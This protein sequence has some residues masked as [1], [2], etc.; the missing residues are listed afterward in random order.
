MTLD[1]VQ[2]IEQFFKDHK[3]YVSRMKF[4]R[5]HYPEIVNNLPNERIIEQLYRLLYGIVDIP[6]CLTCSKP[7]EF[8]TFQKGYKTFC[9]HKCAVSNKQTTLKRKKTNLEKYGSE[10]L[11]DCLEIREKRK[12]TMLLKY[13]SEH[14][15]QNLELR[16]V[17][18][19]K[20]R[21]RKQEDWD[22]ISKKRKETN[23]KKYGV[24]NLWDLPEF[25]EKINQTNLKNN[26]SLW[27]QQS[28]FVKEKGRETRRLKFLNN[29]HLRCPG[30]T[31]LFDKFIGINN[32]TNKPILYKW[33]CNS[34]ATIFEDHLDD[35]SLPSCPVCYPE[36]ASSKG[37][38]DLVNFLMKLG[39]NFKLHVKDLIPP[40]EIDIFLP[41][42]S[43][44]IEYCG[45][46]W[47][48]DKKILNY[49]YHQN[50][51]N[52]CKDK[53]VQLITIFEDEWKLKRKICEARIKHILG[54]SNKICNARDC[55]IQPISVLDYSKFLNDN[56]IQ[57][58][59]K[60]KYK[61]GALYNGHLVSVM[62][63]GKSRIA[64]GSNNLGLLE[65]LR[66]S[67]IGNIP[68]IGSKLFTYFIR[69]NHVSTIISY[70]DLRWG[71]G[72]FYK[73]AGFVLSGITSPNYW[74]SFDGMKRHHRYNFTKH[75]LQEKYGPSNKTEKEIMDNLGYYRIYD[76]GNYK[77]EWNR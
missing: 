8:D 50:K 19:Q 35:G 67:T 12:Q 40:K 52:Q 14:P 13:G 16:K 69:N 63:F 34:C 36:N 3:S 60:S 43:I 37:E 42:F 59:I 39:V 47:H 2:N 18:D 65:L 10:Y 7:V 20:N 61:L 53:R 21:N 41:D 1:T 38:A 25:V 51:W 32:E 27:S 57:G 72:Q 55:E 56:H 64:L 62:G 33:Q 29:I 66:F 70:C 30:Y 26:G 54:F 15:L 76:C 58:Y 46:Y 71:N 44:A 74:Y 17:V 68:G 73:Q 28:N 23:L 9:S 49:K 45:L 24:A 77:F 6:V 5:D 11:L 4:L 75:K 48:S 31:P 22:N